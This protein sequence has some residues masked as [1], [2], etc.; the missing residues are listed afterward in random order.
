MHALKTLSTFGKR[1]MATKVAPTQELVRLLSRLWTFKRPC[2]PHLR[3][4]AGKLGMKSNKKSS[5]PRAR[6][7]QI[8]KGR[9]TFVRLRLDQKTYNWV[10]V[11]SCPRRPGDELGAVRNLTFVTLRPVSSIS[12]RAAQDSCVSP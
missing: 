12:S 9:L 10:Q 6:L 7:W 5:E 2:H 4:L 8:Y 11:A 1:V 3:L